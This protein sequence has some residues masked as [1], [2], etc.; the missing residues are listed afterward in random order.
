MFTDH[1]RSCYLQQIGIQRPIGR[2][3]AKSET[4]ELSALNG[5]SP[6]NASLQGFRMEYGI[7]NDYKSQRKWRK[8]GPLNQY[9]QR[10]YDIIESHRAC[11]VLQEMVS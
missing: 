2:R 7:Q 4:K 11:M 10:S 9:A 6:S 8:Q 3:C 5:L 1:Q